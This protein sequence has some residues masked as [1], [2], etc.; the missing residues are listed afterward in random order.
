MYIS[1]RE[2]PGWLSGKESACNAGDTCLIPGLGRSPGGGHGNPLQYSCLGN[3]MD[4]GAWPATEHRVTKSPT[5]LKQ[6][7]MHHT[8]LI[9][10]T[11][12][13]DQS[14]EGRERTLRR[15]SRSQSPLVPTHLPQPGGCHL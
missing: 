9:R 13:K 11:T 1:L 6:L 4:R 3:P 10:T 5:Q 2:L 8:Y 12:T 15:L 7:S 14:V